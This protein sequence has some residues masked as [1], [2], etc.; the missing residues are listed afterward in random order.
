[1]TI[2]F[3]PGAFESQIGKKVP[4]LNENR[5]IIGEA[6]VLDEDGGMSIKI[7]GEDYNDH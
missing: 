7:F 1:M 5:E 6:T 3:A 2:E 4:V